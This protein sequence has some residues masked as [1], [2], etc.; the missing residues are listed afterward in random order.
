M[1]L[2][3]LGHG[4]V[5]LHAEQRGLMIDPY[6]SGQFDGKMAYRP[7]DVACDYV[8]CSHDHADHAAVHTV[9]ATVV[10]DGR[11]GPFMIRR[12]ALW[13]DEA[14]GRRRGGSV[15]ALRIDTRSSSVLY[16]ADVGES[17]RADLVAQHRGV[18]VLL[19]PVGGFYTIGAA[20]AWEWIE[21]IGPKVAIPVH[22]RTEAC[23]LPIRDHVPFSGWC[24]GAVIWNSHR[25]HVEKMCP[26]RLILT[27]RLA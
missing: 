4:C 1:E 23:H 10:H 25:I 16:L 2:E 19:I 27:P 12:T 26:N 9:D 17:P 11:V 21:R 7:I 3:F 6:E 14:G 5:I 13:H 18:D 22:Y 24:D 15:D 20:Q 8:V